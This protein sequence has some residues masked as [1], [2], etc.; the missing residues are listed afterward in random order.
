MKRDAQGCSSSLQ[1]HLPDTYILRQY[2]PTLN[3]AS[4]YDMYF[5]HGT[6]L[7]FSRDIPTPVRDGYIFKGWTDSGYDITGGRITSS[8]T[9]TAKWEPKN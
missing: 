7:K 9:I 3:N 1:L 4:V 2:F 5:Y 6:K 8:F